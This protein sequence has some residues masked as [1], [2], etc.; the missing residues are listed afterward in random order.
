MERA[1]DLVERQSGPSRKHP[2]WPVPSATTLH[3]WP[4]SCSSHLALS[5]RRPFPPSPATL[6]ASRGLQ[7]PPA[8]WPLVASGSEAATG[9]FTP[10]MA[11]SHLVLLPQKQLHFNFP[12]AKSVK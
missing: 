1:L 11:A 4:P 6:L 8:L 7:P 12:I 5:S 2:R 10:S 9:P 3:Q